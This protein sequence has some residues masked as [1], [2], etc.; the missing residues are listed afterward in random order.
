[1]A[2]VDKAL[3]LKLAKQ[4][5]EENETEPLEKRS[6]TKNSDDVG[7]EQGFIKSQSLLLQPMYQISL[8]LCHSCSTESKQNKP[9]VSGDKATISLTMCESCIKMN[10]HL[11]YKYRDVQVF[12]N[13]KF[14]KS[15]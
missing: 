11:R 1:M 6:R 7:E 8:I 12:K 9:A 2:S 3:L 13:S 10:H 5:E 4:L 15:K 14:E